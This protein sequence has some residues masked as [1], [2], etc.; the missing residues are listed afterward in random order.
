[1]AP[2]AAGSARA[3]GLLLAT[4]S[5][6]DAH[7]FTQCPQPRQCRLWH[8]SSPG[9]GESWQAGADGPVSQNPCGF[10]AADVRQAAS[11]S[12]PCARVAAAVR[13]LCTASD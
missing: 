1:M 9:E 5:L 13:R 6:A 12:T 3:V 10:P 2:A 11:G 8:P 4:A 7:L